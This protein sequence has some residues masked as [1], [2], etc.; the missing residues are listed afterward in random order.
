M[1]ASQ[2][3][4]RYSSG[5]H[6]RSPPSFARSHP[7]LFT[8]KGTLSGPTN[9]SEH[10]PVS[11]SHWN[12]RVSQTR[13][14]PSYDPLT[15]REPSC[16]MERCPIPSK[17]PI[18]VGPIRDP[19]FTSQQQIA[20]KGEPVYK[21]CSSGENTADVMRPLSCDIKERRFSELRF[22]RWM[23]SYKQV[24]IHFPVRENATWIVV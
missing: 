7:S 8:L 18:S 6:R 14:M 16:E 11:V 2:T 13:A 17:W 22:H 1:F 4:N 10:R 19:S 23:L 20:P 3:L 5:T 21:R 12:K 9:P 24:A 15:I